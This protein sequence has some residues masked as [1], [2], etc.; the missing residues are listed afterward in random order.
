MTLR[1]TFSAK[2]L[3]DGVRPDRGPSE[4]CEDWEGFTADVLSG[5]SGS[6]FEYENELL[7][8]DTLEKAVRD[9]ELRQFPDWHGYEAR[10]VRTDATLQRLLQSGVEVRPGRPWWWSHLPPHGGRDFAEDVRR[11]YAIDIDEGGV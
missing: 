7:V 8:R 1:D 3:R 5:Y 11:I 2:V 9:P 6:L 4:Y 10:I